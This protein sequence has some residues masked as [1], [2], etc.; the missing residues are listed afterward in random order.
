MLD[1]RD[2]I[3]DGHLT[4]L[5]LNSQYRDQGNPWMKS[6]GNMPFKTSVSTLLRLPAPYA[7]QCGTVGKCHSHRLLRQMPAC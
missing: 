3:K 4:L 7:V 2:G 5:K 1:L 6:L